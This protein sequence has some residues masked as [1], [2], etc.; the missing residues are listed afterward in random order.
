MEGGITEIMTDEERIARINENIFWWG[1]A[2]FM[3]APKHQERINQLMKGG[4][5][6]G[7][8]RGLGTAGHSFGPG[9]SDDTQHQ[10]PANPSGRSLK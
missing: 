5:E 6:K 10:S 4:N 2:H 3:A 9:S 1:R 7:N 8:D